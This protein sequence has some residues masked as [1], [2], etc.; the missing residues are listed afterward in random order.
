MILTVLRA[1][2]M[3]YEDKNFIND[4]GSQKFRRFIKRNGLVNFG[5]IGS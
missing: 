4:A 2:K 1:S 3:K 5:F